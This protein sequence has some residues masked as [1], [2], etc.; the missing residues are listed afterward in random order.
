MFSRVAK[1][2]NRLSDFL[3]ES[4]ADEEIVLG[5]STSYANS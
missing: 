3:Y 5:S 4:S 1:S 2:Y